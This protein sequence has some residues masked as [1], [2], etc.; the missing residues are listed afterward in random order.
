MKY[1]FAISLLILAGLFSVNFCKAQQMEKPIWQTSEY[2]VFKGRIVQNKFVGKALSATELVSNYQSPANEFQSNKITFKFSINGYDNEMASGTDHEFIITPGITQTP[3]IKFGQQ[4]K[5]KKS[6]EN[7]A[8]LKPDSKLKIRLDMSEVNNSF[9]STGFYTTINGNKIFKEDFKGVFIAGG[10]AP[11]TWDF[12]NLGQ[13]HE[14]E[15]NDNNADGIY[16]I[17]LTFNAQ[18]DQ[19]HTG[20]SWKK[21]LNTSAFPQYKSDFLLA[22]AIYNMSLEEMVKAIEPDST[23]RTGKEWAGVWTR[24]ISYSIILSMAH[25]QPKVAMKSLM[26]KVNS[27]L[28]IIQDTGTGGAYPVSTDRMIWAVAAWEIYKVTGDQN[29]L[30]NAYRIIRNSIEDDLLNA[31]NPETGMVRGESSFLDWREQTYPKWMQPADIF[32]SENLGTN[33]VHFQANKVLSEM[34]FIL[35]QQEVSIKHRKIAERIQLGINQKLWMSDKGYY[36]QFLYGRHA[37]IISPRSEALGEALTLLFDIADSLKQNLIIEKTPVTAFGISCI[38]PQ[39][40]NI[41]PYHNNGV[42]PFVQSYWALASAKAN[43]QKSVMESISAVYRPAAL[44]LTNKENFVADNG[45][46]AGTQINSSNMLWSLSGSLGL[47]HKLIFG[48]HFNPDGLEFKPFVPDLLKGERSL[49]N[50]KYRNA[51]LDIEMEGSGN[52]IKSFSLDG[53]NQERA[54]ISTNLKGR[55]SIKIVLENNLLPEGEINKVANYVSP[56]APQSNYSAGTFW[57]NAVENADRYLVLKNGIFTDSTTKTSFKVSEKEHS[58]YQIIAVDKNGVQSFA[59][60][61]IL[62]ANKNLISIYEAEGFSAKADKPYK[63]FSGLGFTEISKS[64]NT[65][66]NFPIT[67]SQTGLYAI[68]FQYANGNGP[69]NTNNKCAIRTLIDKD[70]FLGTIVFPQRGNEEWSNWGYSNSVKVRLK[71]G[72]HTLRLNFEPANENMNLEVNQ[73]MLDHMRIIKLID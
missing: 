38:F 27:N 2:S 36:A 55:H 35:K 6:N 73:A 56:A 58:E 39:I 12:D 15:L 47:I 57:W 68:D 11:L 45:D 10:T 70:R 8:F 62:V 32:Q 40:P 44:F 28:R 29:W 19:K 3:V 9:K 26:R 37:A 69:I 54:F 16:E 66:I 1:P 25:L 61:P 60:E 64:K 52:K 23:F 41:P 46:F 5:V 67:I 33:A 71:K 22:D 21:H 24:D 53:K 48:I 50:F 4:L 20:N 7:S 59:S 14:L 31:Y 43:N 34:A 42:W 65:A 49:T 72:K 13:H 17:T 30:Q 51:V 18:K 63:G